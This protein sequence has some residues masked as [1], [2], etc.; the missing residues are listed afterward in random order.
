MLKYPYLIIKQLLESLPNV[1][2]AFWF[3]AQY[4]QESEEAV[5]YVPAVY[6][7]FMPVEFPDVQRRI[8]LASVRFRIHLMTETFIDDDSILTHFD[9]TNEIHK[10]LSGYEAQL[11]VLP[12]FADLAD[13]DDDITVINQCTRTQLIPD[14]SQ[15]NLTITTQ[16][17]Q[18]SIMDVEAIRA[19]NEQIITSS[20]IRP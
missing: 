10:A 16:E 7:E 17:Y 11:S 18:A 5:Y 19:Y 4:D 2:A 9:I 14:H 13:T 1:P 8:Q 12:E 15:T 3:N 6:I 20:V